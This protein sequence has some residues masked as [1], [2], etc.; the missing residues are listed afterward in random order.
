MA[1]VMLAACV[2]LALCG[3]IAAAVRAEDRSADQ[4]LDDIKKAE[5]PTIDPAKRNDRAAI[6]DYLTKMQQVAK[7]RC[8]LIGELYQVDPKNP[9]LI[10]LLPERW[11]TMVQQS[12][13]PAPS[14]ELKAE[15]RRGD[16]GLS[17]RGAARRSRVHGRVVR[18]A[19]RRW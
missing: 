4:I 19:L 10:R 17:G 6:L 11:M 13:S 8:E 3:G 2:A 7:R 5:R 1:K 9:E 14:P 18:S 15:A 12:S 16:V